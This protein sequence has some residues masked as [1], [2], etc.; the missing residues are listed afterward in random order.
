[1][2][3]LA[4]HRQ[5][6]MIVTKN[7]LV[8]R[9]ADLLRE[10]A[11]YDAASVT[12]S[13]TTLD[14]EL[15]ASMEP[16]TSSPARRLDAI[17]RLADAGVPVGVFVAPVI[18]GL[19][20]V[21]LP[22]IVAAAARAGASFAGTTL[23]RLPHAVEAVFTDWLATRDPARAR[24]IVARIREARD[25]RMN[26]AAFGSRMRGSGDYADQIRA[27]FDLARRRHGLTGP[28]ALSAAS[29][30]VPGRAHQPRLFGGE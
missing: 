2:T 25:G 16:R 9:D 4:E 6:V 26:D 17:A 27:L 24:R 8:T 30:R 12:L 19:T 18:P 29:F 10:L 5:P 1:L 13:I 23:L 28:P 22:E 20:D 15:R 7:H 11:Q 14:D 3:V 21:E